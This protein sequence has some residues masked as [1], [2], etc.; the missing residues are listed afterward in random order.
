MML[1]CALAVALSKPPAVLA[2]GGLLIGSYNAHHWTQSP[3]A[4]PTWKRLRFQEVK[5]GKVGKSVVVSEP[6]IMQMS[7]LP[8]L[9]PDGDKWLGAMW[10]G[11]TP[12]FPRKVMLGSKVSAKAQETVKD[13]VGA[14]G[15]GNTRIIWRRDVTGDFDGDGKSDELIECR[16]EKDGKAAWSMV[17]LFQGGKKPRTLAW[18]TLKEDQ[19]TLVSIEGLADF[20]REGTM[21]VVLSRTYLEGNGG[22]LWRLGRNGPVKLVENDS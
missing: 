4:L 22:V 11:P 10:S 6:V 5:I 17:I 20:D 7:G 2:V 19:L 16:G 12:K 1:A 9:K 15:F 13:W 8:Y 21:E 3:E 18:E 14:H